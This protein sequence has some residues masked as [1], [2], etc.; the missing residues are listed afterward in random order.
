MRHPRSCLRL[1][2]HGRCFDPGR[3]GL[4][5]QPRQGRGIPNASLAHAIGFTGRQRS[6]VCQGQLDPW[7][8]VHPLSGTRSLS[9]KLCQ[10]YQD[11]RD[12]PRN[13]GESEKIFKRRR[14]ARADLER[15]LLVGNG[16]APAGSS[17][18]A[19]LR[20]RSGHF[21]SGAGHHAPV[22]VLRRVAR[23]R[24]LAPCQGSHSA[25]P[26]SSHLP[27]YLN[28]EKPTLGLADG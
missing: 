22:G 24:R 9:V 12:L 28:G 1:K 25:P 4:H 3:K 5:H 21:S 8:S 14:T 27:S 7:F 6:L 13:P 11:I 16:S 18:P 23:W 10:K 17:A 19:C 2:R 26:Y 15:I 20:R